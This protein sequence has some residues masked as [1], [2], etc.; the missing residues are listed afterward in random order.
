VFKCW[1]IF[2]SSHRRRSSKQEELLQEKLRTYC[3]VNMEIKEEPCRIKEED[4]EE[5][6]GWCFPSFC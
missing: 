4:T 1:G 5:Q 2:P 3:I 6:I